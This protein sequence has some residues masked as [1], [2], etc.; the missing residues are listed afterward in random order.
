LATLYDIMYCRFT[1]VHEMLAALG[2]L[3]DAVLSTFSTSRS[4]KC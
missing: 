2:V 3:A 1:D 4:A